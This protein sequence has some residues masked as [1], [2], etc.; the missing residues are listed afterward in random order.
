MAKNQTIGQDAD[1]EGYYAKW[2]MKSR[3]KLLLWIKKR[4]DKNP[5]KCMALVK[6]VRSTREGRTSKVGWQYN[7]CVTRHDMIGNRVH[8]V[9]R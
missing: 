3:Q 1:P 6:I 5:C 9:H 8:T 7:T 4:I 2:K